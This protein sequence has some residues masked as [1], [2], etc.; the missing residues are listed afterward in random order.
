MAY[1]FNI[2][3]PWD[4]AKLKD[5]SR[6]KWPISFLK[7]KNIPSFVYLEPPAKT[8][9]RVRFLTEQVC[10]RRKKWVV[11]FGNDL[12]YVSKL[13][14][15]VVASFALTTGLSAEITTP[16][17]LVNFAFNF[18]DNMQFGISVHPFEACGLLIIPYFDPMYP[19]Y[20][21]ARPRITELLQERKLR[22]KPYIIGIFVPGELPTN[23]EGLSK[24]T[25][26]LLDIVGYEAQ[27]LFE[28]GR[29]K[30]VTV[31]TENL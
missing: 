14:Y 26:A 4:K 19:G 16:K 25:P 15:Y 29:T 13:F 22:G 8:A 11:C 2:V 20:Q 6:L 23:L 31:T 21:K 12:T 7:D 30:S 1:E 17:K 9:E 27:S 10:A 18:G 5:D 3:L 24:Y 28:D